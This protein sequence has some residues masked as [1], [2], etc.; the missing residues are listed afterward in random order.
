[1]FTTWR[2]VGYAIACICACEA[3]AAALLS[4][5]RSH[6]HPTRTRWF[7]VHAL[8]NGVVATGTARDAMQLAHLSAEACRPGQPDVSALPITLTV[9]LHAWHAIAYDLSRG[10]RFHHGLFIPLIGVPGCLYDWGRCGNAQLFFMSGAPG[11]A[12]YA[13][14]VLQ[15]CNLVLSIQEPAF[16]AIVTSFVR[17]PGSLLACAQLLLALRAGSLHVPA[18]AAIV[19]LG[20]SPFNAFYYAAQ[21]TLRWFRKTHGPHAHGPLE[22]PLERPHEHAL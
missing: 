1:M 16:T 12:V 5:A 17:L 6:R 10:D 11:G 20:L 19:Q 8:C 22:R 15:T 4:R 9:A 21:T 2:D 7:L 3:V 18:A 14:L 13:L